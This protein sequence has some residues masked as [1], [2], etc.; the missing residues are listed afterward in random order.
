MTHPYKESEKQTR[1]RKCDPGRSQ[2]EATIHIL[3]VEEKPLE[4]P[5]HPQTD[6]KLPVLDIRHELLSWSP[7]VCL[8]HL[9]ELQEI[10]AETVMISS[11]IL[12]PA[13]NG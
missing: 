8:V 6:P 11:L 7:S 9:W 10:E 5:V 4:E 12:C 2:E 1:H 3:H 13:Y